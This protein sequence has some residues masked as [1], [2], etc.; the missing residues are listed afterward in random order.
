VFSLKHE[1]RETDSDPFDPPKS[2]QSVRGSLDDLSSQNLYRKMFTTGRSMRI[3]N[4]TFP[5]NFIVR[6]M[7][8][9]LESSTLG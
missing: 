1:D 3:F 2:M 6:P 7:N 8:E 4:I 5:L 9:A